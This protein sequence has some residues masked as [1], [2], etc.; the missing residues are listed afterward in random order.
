MHAYL[1]FDHKICF[2]NLTGKSLIKWV[3]FDSSLIHVCVM[4][5]DVTPAGGWVFCVWLWQGCG[6]RGSYIISDGF[7]D[8]RINGLH[9]NG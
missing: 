6:D 3:K 8:G 5:C 2:V 7:V 1:R 9:F 4:S